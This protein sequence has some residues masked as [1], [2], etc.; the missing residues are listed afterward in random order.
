MSDQA[1]A[2]ILI[3][4]DTPANLDILFRYLSR[5][6]FKVLVARDGESA[7]NQAR[8]SQPELIL[9]DVMMPG[10]DGFETCR[11][12]QEDQETAE[13]P[14]I[15]MTALS[16]VKD[17]LRGF[18]AGGVDYV[19]KPLEHLEVLARINT[20]LTISRLQKELKRKNQA[21]QDALD[22]VKVL[23]GLIPICANCH[24]I[25]DD[26]GF[27]H[28]VE[29]Y[30]REHSDATFTHGIC[31]DCTRSLYPEVADALDDYKGEDV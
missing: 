2:R 11:R 7:I 16:E 14:V 19:T 18:E 22:K 13:I 20:H 1:P 5:Q 12:L 27:W 15:F 17:K 29:T 9:L 8:Y 31:P 3:V 28:R 23:S 25:R 24:K 6:G 30:I 26:Q 4:D 10:I 21:L